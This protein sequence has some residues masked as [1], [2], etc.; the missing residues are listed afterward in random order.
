MIDSVM[1]C[2]LG[3][4]CRF[5]IDW[6]GHYYQSGVGAVVIRGGFVTTKGV[7]VEQERDYYLFSNRSAT[8]RLRT[9]DRIITGPP[10]RR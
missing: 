1:S 9:V 8:Y 6:K 7:C 3:P 5:P 4:T 2:V 10:T